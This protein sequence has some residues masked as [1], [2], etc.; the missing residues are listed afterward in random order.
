MP[1]LD[2]FDLDRIFEV[3][4]DFEKISLLL[5]NAHSFALEPV[6]HVA[7]FKSVFLFHRI[8]ADSGVG[9]RQLAAGVSISLYTHSGEETI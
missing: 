6:Y 1:N 5:L 4:R 8:G 7:N 9:H 2:S 3:Y